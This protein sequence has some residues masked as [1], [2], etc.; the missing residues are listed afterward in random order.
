MAK[1][2]FSLVSSKELANQIAAKN[3]SVKKLPTWYQHK[4][5]FYPALLSIEQ[6]SSE[7]TAAYK[8]SLVTGESLIDLTGGF[9]VD[10]LYFAKKLK[11]VT[12]CEINEEL[13]EIAAYNATVL[14]HDNIRFLATDG[15]EYL[16]AQKE[17]F[18]NIYIDPARRSQSGKVFMLKDCTPDVV[19][20]LDLLLSRS[21]RILIK[22]APL[23]DISAGLKELRNVSEVHVISVKNECKELIWIVENNPADQ[24]K[25]VCTTLNEQEKSFS[26]FKGIED[27]AADHSAVNLP[28]TGLEHYLYEPDTAL[29]KGGAFNLIASRYGIKKLSPQTQLY[30]SEQIIEEFPGRRFKINRIISA[31]DL[32]R[33]KDL[34]GNVIA[35]NYQDKAEN[36]VKKYKIKP[37]N[38]RFLIFTQS[39]KEGYIVIDATIEQHY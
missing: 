25:I 24:L 10:S 12:H 23:L 22:T 37:D 27:V 13:S 7:R 15:I 30:T 26:F 11:T 33:E 1:S 20:H 14:Q 17:Q 6:C 39:K 5:I 36:I 4:L 3:K 28:E 21:K 9:G 38:H 35:R 29:L 8:A 31:A 2:P 34:K 32:K 16:K 18:D 19:T